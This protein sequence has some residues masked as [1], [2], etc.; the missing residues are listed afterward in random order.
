MSETIETAAE[1]TLDDVISEFQSTARPE[2]TVHQQ[3]PS[4]APQYQAPTPQRFDP[5]DESSVNNWV[6]Q[7]SQ[8]HSALDQ[9]VRQLSTQLSDYQQR[10]VQKQVEADIS[11]AVKVLTNEV[12]VKPRVAEAYLEA[13]AREKPGFKAIWDNRGNNPTAYQKALKA[14][15]ADM[16]QDFS[17]RTDP[18]LVDDLR[19]AKHSQQAMATTKQTSANDAW[20]GLSEAEFQR[21]W[22]QMVSGR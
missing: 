15:S 14:I 17:A 19:A 10:E 3:S 2:P 12:D 7:Q 11:A 13:M 8:A 16:K 18:K 22:S 4:P 9:Q 1:P 6:T 20:E 21:K 5:L